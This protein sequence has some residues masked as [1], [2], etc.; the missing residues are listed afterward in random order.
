[1][2][3]SNDQLRRLL[4]KYK[5]KVA[6]AKTPSWRKKPAPKVVSQ[7]VVKPKTP[8]RYNPNDDYYDP[9]HVTIT[10]LPKEAAK[11]PLGLM[12]F[13][14]EG[15]KVLVSEMQNFV[16]ERAPNGTYSVLRIKPRSVVARRLRLK[17]VLP[18]MRK[19]NN[20]DV[21][22]AVR[23]AERER[24]TAQQAQNRIDAFENN[25]GFYIV[26]GETVGPDDEIH[27]ATGPYYRFEN[28]G[29]NFEDLPEGEFETDDDVEEEAIIQMRR[30]DGKRVKIIEARNAREAAAGRGHVWWDQ[31]NLRSPP[32]DPRQKGFGW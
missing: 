16:A 25:P 29:R 7:P 8:K 22:F 5:G 23:A 31:G 26:P 11:V 12:W 20:M 30:G 3:T 21:N 19:Y 4:A 14:F 32:V 6:S 1:M 27:N 9:V 2:A 13:T 18:T 10:K 24:E 17:D 15:V 28:I